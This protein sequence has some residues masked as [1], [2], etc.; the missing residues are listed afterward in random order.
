MDN[1]VQTKAVLDET[2]QQLNLKLHE[3]FQSK[4]QALLEQ[5]KQELVEAQKEL[6]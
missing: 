3:H 6:N 4:E 5:Y 1:I 2:I